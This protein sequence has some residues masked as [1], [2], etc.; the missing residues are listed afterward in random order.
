MYKNEFDNLLRNKKVFNSY[1]FYGQ[2]TYLIEYYTNIIATA[3]AQKEDVEKIYFDDYDFKYAKQKLLQ[4]SLFAPSSVLIIKIDKKL[5]KKETTELIEACNKN[6]TNKVV[7]SCMGDGEFKTMAGYFNE[8]KNS[9]V[10]VRMFTPS[11]SEAIKLLEIEALNLKM[12]CDISSL[13]H[14]YFMHKQNITLCVNDLKKLSVYDE[15]ITSKMVDI[16]CF[17]T[18]SISLDEFLHKLLAGENINEDLNTLLEEGVNEIFLINQI[19][20]FVQQLF[21]ISSYTRA[22]GVPN[23]KEILGFIPPKNVWERKCKIAISIKPNRFLEIF[24]LLSSVELELKS[25]KI[26]EQNSYIQSI[27]RNF[28]ANL[29]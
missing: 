12:D 14:L 28:S 5:N 10:S 29:L 26:S 8:K 18:G 16:H 7:F 23:A 1:M 22:F 24:E 21:M 17:G 19:Q 20:S 15:P 27:L 25:S 3:F 2:S 6:P 13:N 4:P 9:A 11:Q